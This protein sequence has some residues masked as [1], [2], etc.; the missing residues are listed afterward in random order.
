MTVKEINLRVILSKEIPFILIEQIKTEKWTPQRYKDFLEISESSESNFILGIFKGQV[1]I[2]FCF[3]SLN[4]LENCAFI[5]TVSL[6]KEH[7]ENGK[8]LKS[9]IE[10]LKEFIRIG[11]LT[12]AKFMTD[13]PAY[14]KRM[15]LKESKQ[16][17]LEYRVD[18]G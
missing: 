15:K 11:R 13:R 10:K 12:S 7:R 17:I 6:Y 2:G 4:F 3:I 9:V 5:N 18:H 8:T 14:F 1:L 16:T